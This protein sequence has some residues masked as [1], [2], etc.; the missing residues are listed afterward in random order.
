MEITCNI[1]L[2]AINN[3]NSTCAYLL[4]IGLLGNF[5]IGT[6][7]DGYCEPEKC[8]PVSTSKVLFIIG[9]SV[10]ALGDS[11][12]FIFLF[13]LGS[14]SSDRSVYLFRL[15]GTFFSASKVVEQVNYYNDSSIEKS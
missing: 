7:L 15:E 3:C 9:S 4:F 8:L 11:V 14:F 13:P 6:E 1:V 2:L 12:R 10:L 5:P